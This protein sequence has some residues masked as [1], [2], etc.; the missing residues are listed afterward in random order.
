MYGMASSSVSFCLFPRVLLLGQVNTI[1]AVYCQV[2][3]LIKVTFAPLIQDI[4]YA[5]FR[6]FFTLEHGSFYP[7]ILPDKALSSSAGASRTIVRGTG[8]YVAR[9]SC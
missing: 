2:F 7:Y 8:E 4:I 9:L 6:Q 5:F 3:I 1:N